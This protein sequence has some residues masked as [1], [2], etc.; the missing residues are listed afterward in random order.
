MTP[1]NDGLWLRLETVMA[2][3]LVILEDPHYERGCLQCCPH[4]V[5]DS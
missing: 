5:V 2:A 1:T 4:K 3:A